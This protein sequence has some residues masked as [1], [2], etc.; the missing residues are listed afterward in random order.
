MKTIF[1]V[2][3]EYEHHIIQ[4]KDYIHTEYEYLWEEF[5]IKDAHPLF[6]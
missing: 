2:H 4:N 6:G 5:E 1:K 3:Y